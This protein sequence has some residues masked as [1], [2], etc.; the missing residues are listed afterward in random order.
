GS[1]EM[2]A[3]SKRRPTVIL[4]G[5]LLVTGQD[6]ARVTLSGLLVAGGG[7]VLSGS[8]TRLRIEHCTLAPSGSAPSLTADSPLSEIEIDHAITG[9]IRANADTTVTISGSIVDATSE[10]ATAYAA[11]DGKSF[12]GTLAI[13][14]S[15]IIG[16]IAT[17]LMQ[18]ASN[19]IFLARVDPPD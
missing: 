7:V 10:A 12:G 18:M 19:T 17:R 1:I 4:S 13:T 16:K 14:N 6:G 11:L 5:D 3:A 15:T 8:S 9:G 2:R